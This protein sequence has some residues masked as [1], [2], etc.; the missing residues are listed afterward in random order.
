MIYCALRL[1]QK[2]CQWKGGFQV[3]ILKEGKKGEKYARLKISG[4]KKVKLSKYEIFGSIQS[5]YVQ[6]GKRES[7]P[8]KWNEPAYFSET[9]FSTC[10]KK[11]NKRNYPH[12]VII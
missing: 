4:N 5:Q 10:T 9:L 7:V 11:E 8:Q 3:A 6:E 12:G 1:N 2:W